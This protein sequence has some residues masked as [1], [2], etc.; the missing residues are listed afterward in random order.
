MTLVMNLTRE[1]ATG[2]DDD[3]GVGLGASGKGGG[4]GVETDLGLDPWSSHGPAYNLT[5]LFT[6]PGGGGNLYNLT[7]QLGPG[8]GG[9]SPPPGGPGVGLPSIVCLSAFFCIIGVIGIVGNLLVIFIIVCDRK[10]RRSVTNLFIMNLAVSD[11]LIMLF[12]VPEIVLFMINSGW[13]LG[14]ALCKTQRYVLVFSLYSSVV[15]LV[16]VCIER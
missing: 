13:L 10:M 14:E 12:G 5:D 3:W 8:E 11:L 6:R 16:S 15:T 1:A 2:A 9:T 7:S 4:Y